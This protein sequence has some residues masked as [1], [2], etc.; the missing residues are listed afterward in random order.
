MSMHSGHS[1]P[2][3]CGVTGVA[4]HATSNEIRR[5]VQQD[6]VTMCDSL[7]VAE[8]TRQNEKES[9]PIRQVTRHSVNYCA[10]SFFDC[11]S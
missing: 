4:R 5:S 1:P 7:K 9:F 8:R 2:G 10:T 11:V 3:G 6:N